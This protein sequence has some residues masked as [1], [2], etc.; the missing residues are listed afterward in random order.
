M[1]ERLKLETIPAEELQRIKGVTFPAGMKFRELLVTGPPGSGKTKLINMVGG[2]PE[3]GYIDLTLK[4]WWRAQSLTYRP[5]EVH[6]GFPFVGYDEALTV[7]DKKWLEASPPP[8]L[9]LPRIFLPP[10]KTHFLGV[11]WRERF[12]FEFLIPPPEAIL[13]WRLEPARREAHPVDEGVTLEQVEKQVAVYCE[14]ALHFHRSGLLTYVRD[15]YDGVPKNIVD[16]E[17]T[18]SQSAKVHHWGT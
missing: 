2:W 17:R 6:F 11:E 16:T 7:F 15:D 8:Q 5:R 12:V 4:N 13:K 14:I 18:G 3:E 9:D 10:P 1:T